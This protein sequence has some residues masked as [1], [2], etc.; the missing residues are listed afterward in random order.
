MSSL[1]SAANLKSNLFFAISKASD[2]GEKRT[3]VVGVFIL[4][5]Y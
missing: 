2:F 3:S 5:V 1:F 4:I